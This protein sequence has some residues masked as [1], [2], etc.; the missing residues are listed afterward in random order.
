MKE[1]TVPS[2]PLLSK[3]QDGGT[4][5]ELPGGSGEDRI[6]DMLRFSRPFGYAAGEQ[7]VVEGAG[8]R[9][10]YYVEKG[11]VEVSYRVGDTPIVVA[12]IGPSSFFGEIGFFDGVSRVRDIRATED[13][14]IRLFDADSVANMREQDPVLY[15]DFVALMAQSI[16][17]K[18]RRVVEEREPLTAYAASLSAGRR[19]FEEAQT[20]PS[21]PAANR[22]VA[23]RQPVGRGFQ[24]ILLRPLTS[25]A[26]GHESRGPAA[27]AGPVSPGDGRLQRKA[28]DGCGPS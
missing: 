2:D 24:D 14:V 7:V 23:L 28:P 4:S 21:A 13:S 22:G 15:G 5:N 16:C 9:C 17:E 25:V 6:P 1:P 27:A 11:S 8:S 19:A 10:L 3:D 26:A 18:F 12:L 20:N